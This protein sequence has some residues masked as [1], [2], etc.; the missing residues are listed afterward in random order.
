MSATNNYS[1]IYFT[2][3]AGGFTSPNFPNSFSRAYSN[4]GTNVQGARV[5]NHSWGSN[6]GAGVYNANSQ[7]FDA[8]VRDAQPAGSTHPAAG[9]Q[10]IVVVVAAG[11]SGPGATTVG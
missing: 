8:L 2:A 10:P 11:N 4:L 3:A 5:S 6:P 9:N 1:S 7:T